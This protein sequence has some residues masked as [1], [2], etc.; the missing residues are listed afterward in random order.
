MVERCLQN[1]PDYL[2]GKCSR[3][4]P[5]ALCL[6]VACL[7]PP[8]L[9]GG[10]PLSPRGLPPLPPALPAGP[11]PLQTRVPCSLPRPGA[12]QVSTGKHTWP[13]L[14]KRHTPGLFLVKRHTPGPVLVKRHT[15]GRVLVRN[16]HTCPG[17][18][19]RHTPGPVLVRDTHLSWPSLDIHTW[20][21][22]R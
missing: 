8:P 2:N 16:T 5:S 17:P 15:S 22:P 20:P 18:R 14:V 11:H 10:P 9:Q 13:V 19:Q 7:L 3:K 12:H 21:G 4:S 1:S 6:Q